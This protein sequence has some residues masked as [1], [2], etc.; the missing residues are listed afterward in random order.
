MIELEDIFAA[1]SFGGFFYTRAQ[2]SRTND[3][4]RARRRLKGNDNARG[5]DWWIK[6]FG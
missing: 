1:H 5:K 2:F 6:C 3:I 4:K